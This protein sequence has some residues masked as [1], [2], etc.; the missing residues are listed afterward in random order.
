M[1]ISHSKTDFSTTVE[2]AFEEIDPNYMDYKGIVITGS[3]APEDIQEKLDL[4]KLAREEN[5]PFLGICMG[6]QL[7]L[8]EFARNVL[9]IKDATSEELGKGTP[10]ITK[11]RNLNVGIRQIN[12]KSETRY[13]SFWHH[14]KFNKKYTDEFTKAGMGLV[15]M[16]DIAVIGYLQGRS[17]KAPFFGTQ[18]HPEYQSTLDKPHDDLKLFLDICK[19]V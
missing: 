7:M 4:I 11:M 9:G 15:F 6:F 13:E 18:Y 19:S 14:Y 12:F 2:K 8:I 1:V 10:I 3:H 5:I 17:D 16:D